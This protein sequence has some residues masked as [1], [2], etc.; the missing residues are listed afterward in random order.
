MTRPL[1]E[2]LPAPER[3][4]LNFLSLYDKES[5]RLVTAT[6]MACAMPRPADFCEIEIKSLSVPVQPDTLGVKGAGEA[7][8]V[9]ALPTLANSIFDALSPL[10]VK[11]V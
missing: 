1:A 9:D 7:D 10:G 6:F 11:G 4:R 2:R 8:T 3:V 5:R